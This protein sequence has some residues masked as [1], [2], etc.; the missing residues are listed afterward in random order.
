M[1]RG[2][3]PGGAKWAEGPP[4]EASGTAA[5]TSAPKGTHFFLRA[6]LS[7]ALGALAAPGITLGA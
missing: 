6:Q 1:R 3:E 7:R 5:W 4:G 2:K